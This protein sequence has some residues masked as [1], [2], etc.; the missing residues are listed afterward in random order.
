MARD[1]DKFRLLIEARQIPK[2]SVVTKAT[3]TKMYRLVDELRVY[4]VPN[5]TS[6]PT[7]GEPGS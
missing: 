6:V 7:S 5:F 3:G 2:G 1:G 4:G